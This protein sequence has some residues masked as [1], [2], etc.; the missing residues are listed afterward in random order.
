MLSLTQGKIFIKI[1]YIFKAVQRRIEKWQE[2]SRVHLQI[3]TSLI[4]EVEALIRL[5][6]IFSIVISY[7][8]VSIG[9]FKKDIHNGTEMKC[10]HF[11][12]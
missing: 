10:W 7:Q 6:L 4:K 2:F 5:T 1:A 3:K 12:P 9:E 11:K 8:R